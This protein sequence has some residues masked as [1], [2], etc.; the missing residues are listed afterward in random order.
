MVDNER[1]AA[2]RTVGGPEAMSATGV[3]EQVF[4]RGEQA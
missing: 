4:S 1:S 3:V 2:L